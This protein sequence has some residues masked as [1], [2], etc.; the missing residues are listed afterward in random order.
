MVTVDTS[1]YPTSLEPFNYTPGAAFRAG[2]LWTQRL[3]LKQDLEVHMGRIYTMDTNGWIVAPTAASSVANLTRGYFQA[4]ESW[5]NSGGPSGAGPA[6]DDTADGDRWAGFAMP[7]SFVTLFADADVHPGLMVDLA[8]TG[9]AVTANRC[10]PNTG[11]I[12]NGTI[13]MCME[14]LAIRQAATAS[15]A[16]DRRP[17]NKTAA[18]DKVLVRLGVGL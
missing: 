4:T 14:V 7:T 16:Q 9:T 8:A 18:N 3:P 5:T 12:T 15:R 10:K 6:S 2:Y 11:A 1:T 17:K 13:G